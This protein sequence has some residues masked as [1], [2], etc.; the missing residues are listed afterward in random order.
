[1]RGG[2]RFVGKII[3]S[4]L[5]RHDDSKK[6]RRA[7]DLISKNQTQFSESI[8]RIFVMRPASQ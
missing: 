1:L 8:I 6:T 3:S 2:L 5:A 7:L 4:T